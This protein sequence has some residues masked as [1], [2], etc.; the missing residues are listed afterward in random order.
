MALTDAELLAEVE[1]IIRTMPERFDLDEPDIFSWLGRARAVIRKWD[2]WK[3]IDFDIAV[4][5]LHHSLAI[6][7]H[8]AKRKVQTFLHEA[9]H[10]LRLKT[11]GPLTVAVDQGA[12]FDYF[13]EV[14]KLIETAKS[15]LLFVDPY[16]DAEFVSRYLVHV[17]QNVRVRLL[18][19]ECL[20]T[21]LPAVDAF[22]QQHKLAIE[23]R[24]APGFHDRYIF[25]DGVSCYQSGASFK[26]GAKKAPTTLTQIVDAFPAMLATYELIWST[27]IAQQ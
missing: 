8:D 16:L 21:L 2:Q 12:R 6:V 17:A 13:D 11:V 22:R 23:V 20:L 5:S 4:N 18:T 19:R 26:D 15:E 3:A 9:R 14:R 1:N 27:A 24:S 10:D 25:V 7:A